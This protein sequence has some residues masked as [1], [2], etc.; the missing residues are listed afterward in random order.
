[1]V[2]S[3]KQEWEP[4]GAS[5]TLPMWEN[6]DPLYDLRLFSLKAAVSELGVDPTVCEGLNARMWFGIGRIAKSNI[7]LSQKKEDYNN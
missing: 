6:R 7:V 5:K 3:C 2:R 4:D 1:M